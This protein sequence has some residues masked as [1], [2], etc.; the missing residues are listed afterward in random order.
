MRVRAIVA[1]SLIGATAFVAAGGSVPMLPAGNAGIQ[2]HKTVAAVAVMPTLTLNLSVDHPSAIPGDTL[3][4]SGTVANTAT[5]W[6][7]TGAF[8]AESHS[9]ATATVAYYWD[10]LQYCFQG[11]GNGENRFWTS[12][13]AFVAGQ[14]DYTPVEAPDL[15]GGMA[16]TAVGAPAAGVTYPAA[17][18]GILGSTVAPGATATWSYQAIVTLTPAQ[19]ALLSDPTKVQSTRNLAHFEV[20]TTNPQAAEPWSDSATFTNSFSATT[21]A[22]DAT[23]LVVKVT[24]PNGSTVNVAIG[25]LA[26]GASAPYSTT[27]TV[28]VPAPKAAGETDAAYLSRLT[29]LEGSLLTAN[30]TLSGT[31]SSGPVSAP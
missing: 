18:D 30:A 26:P 5:N 3:T 6:S 23:N 12:I 20:T 9:D 7:L 16:L 27:F 21:N 13:A 17:G 22:G 24:E 19:V 25:T 1:A 29:A 8:T 10:E 15:V 31:G 2:F 4:Y 11:C 14:P 28:P